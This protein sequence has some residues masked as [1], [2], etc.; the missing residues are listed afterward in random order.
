MTSVAIAIHHEA[1][2]TISAPQHSATLDFFVWCANLAS[3]MCSNLY[4][5]RGNDGNVI[6][7]LES[8]THGNYNAFIECRDK[9]P[10]TSEVEIA[11]I[12]AFEALEASNSH[13]VRWTTRGVRAFLRADWTRRYT[14]RVNVEDPKKFDKKNCRPW[15][16]QPVPDSPYKRLVNEPRDYYTPTH[17]ASCSPDPWSDDEY[18]AIGG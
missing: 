5:L 17:P 10:Y 13:T 9:T 7:R 2:Q 15:S 14:G 18:V 11:A 3:K 4:V 6:V 16:S 8:G 1:T 12:T